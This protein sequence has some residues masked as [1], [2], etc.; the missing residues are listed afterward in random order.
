[1]KIFRKKSTQSTPRK[2]TVHI[3]TM[4]FTPHGGYRRFRK[5][6]TPE[7]IYPKHKFI[8]DLGRTNEPNRIE[9][10]LEED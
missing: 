9:I 3:D 1:M 4:L 2:I 7:V 5:T 10:L 6:F 8:V